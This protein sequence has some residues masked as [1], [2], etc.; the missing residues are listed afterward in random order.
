MPPLRRHQLAFPSAEGWRRLFDQA[1]DEDECACL[2]HWAAARLPL[3][4]TRQAVAPSPPATTVQLGL[5]TPPC[6]GRRPLTLRVPST[7]IAWFGE[8]PLLQ[9]VLPLLPRP[10]RGRLQALCHDLVRLGV[11]ARAYG[12]VGWQS[13]TGLPYLHAHSDLDLWL[14][15]DGAQQAD[16]AV[17]AVAALQ[18]G[19]PDTLRIDGELM[20][21]DGA[22]VAWREWAAWRSGGCRALLV[23]RLHGAALECSVGRFAPAVAGTAPAGAA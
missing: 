13:L 4:V 15:V 20:F 5:P 23:K 16:A 14:A 12:S 7:G 10:V 18:R 19:A 11:R 21:V 6:W 2:T 3:V 1:R 8:F 9:Q 22:A 17:A